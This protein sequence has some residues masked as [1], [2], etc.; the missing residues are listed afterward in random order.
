MALGFFL[1]GLLTVAPCKGRITHQPVTCC[2]PVDEADH[3]VDVWN[4]VEVLGNEV[5]PVVD[6]P[7]AM[8]IHPDQL[9]KAVFC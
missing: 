7:Q 8:N 1:L 4:S 9:F 2:D 6:A 3:K 5:Q